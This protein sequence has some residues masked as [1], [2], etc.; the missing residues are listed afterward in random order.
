MKAERGLKL[1]ALMADEII[2]GVF[3]FLVLPQAGVE[4]PLWIS[5]PL[6]VVLL[7]K[8]FLIAPYVL[9]GGLEKKPSTG[10]E[11]L[12]GRKA[13]VVEELDPKGIVKLDGE[14]WRAE[15]V[16]GKARTGEKVVVVEVRGTKV[17]VE[18]QG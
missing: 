1:I 10:P 4:I 7:V 15:C 12:V 5:A 3:L 14:L 16:N 8:D 6:M 9:G 13:L 11:A 18:R 2:V 17:L